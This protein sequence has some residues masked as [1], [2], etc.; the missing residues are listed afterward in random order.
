MDLLAAQRKLS[1]LA[2]LEPGL[3]LGKLVQ[4]AV[5]AQ[6]SQVRFAVGA[7]DLVAKINFP[8]T[9]RA[10]QEVQEH[11]AT[12]FALAQGLRPRELTWLCGGITRNFV[13]PATG[14]G[15]LATEGLAVFRFGRPASLWQELRALVVARRDA[16]ALL[17]QRAYLC[18]IPVFVDAVRI[19][20]PTRAGISSGLE[21]IQLLRR[22]G[23]PRGWLG[24]PSPHALGARTVCLAGQTFQDPTSFGATR[25]PLKPLLLGGAEKRANRG[26]YPSA[27]CAQSSG[28]SAFRRPATVQ[29]LA[30]A[31]VH[32]NRLG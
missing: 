6:A 29:S 16:A 10:D 31:A 22:G 27:R 1:K 18:P 15:P 14:D 17:R 9:A 28:S 3:M 26:P 30:L 25:F 32:S 24:A 12:V 13:G 5:V 19:N 7:G 21:V 11:M 2:E 20:D 4:A 23:L 8:E